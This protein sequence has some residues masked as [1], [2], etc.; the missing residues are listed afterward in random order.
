MT[1][2]T[3]TATT[4]HLA[5]RPGRVRPRPIR[6]PAIALALVAGLVLSAC[7]SAA[8]ITAKNAWVR[9]TDPTKTAAGF[10]LIENAGDR[11]DALISASSP[12]YGKVELHETVAVSGT[13]APASAA[14]SSGMGGMATA[15][16]MASGASMAP[17]MEMRP[18][19]EIPVPAKG[20]VE[21]KS[22]SYHMMLMEP[23]G[24]IK[25]G[26]KIEITLTFKNAGAVKVTA[27]IK[28]V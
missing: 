11:A 9:V 17:M 26:D 10:V 7:T 6:R 28:G 5:G 14:A 12:A 19:S 24:T 21:L 2:D 8:S 23:T 20:S 25:I 1:T 16:P 3:S 18:I 4:E 13:P 15:A 22:G 27:E